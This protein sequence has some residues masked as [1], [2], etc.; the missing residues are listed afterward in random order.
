MDIR[1]FRDKAHIYDIISF[2]IFITLLTILIVG[3]ISIPLFKRIRSNNEIEYCFIKPYTTSNF[4]HYELIGFVPW[5]DN[6]VIFVS[7]DFNETKKIAKEIGCN[8]K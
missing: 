4:T 6:R 8:L 2:R 7:T 3:F 5:A 1:E